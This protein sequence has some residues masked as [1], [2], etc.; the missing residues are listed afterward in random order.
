ML[1]R[2][3][4]PRQRAFTLVELLVAIALT[5]VLLAL[6]APSFSTW[7]RNTQVRTVA[8][9]LQN[10]VRLAQTEALRRNRQVVFFLTND[11]PGLS[12]EGDANGSNWVVRWIPLAGDTVNSASPNFEPFVTGGA[13]ADFTDGVTITG[14][15]AVCFNSQGRR[16][17]ATAS[18]TGVTGAVCDPL[19]ADDPLAVFQ[20]QRGG[21][22]RPLQVT[23]ALGGQV[24]L[25]DP[26]RT[27]GSDVPDGCPAAPPP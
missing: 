11:A 19:D 17:A 16:V 21:A 2:A 25:C 9:T 18:V 27:L 15:V 14:P 4:A 6:A 5:G 8:E 24:R 13:I 20:M 1:T 3:M 22:D 10:G 23:V 12:A 26:A 7:I